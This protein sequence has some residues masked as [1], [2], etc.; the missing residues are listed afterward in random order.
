M[1]GQHEQAIRSFQA[2]ARIGDKKAQKHLIS[3]GMKW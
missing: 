1:L 3:I 2:A